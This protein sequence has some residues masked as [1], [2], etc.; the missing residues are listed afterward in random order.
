MLHCLSYQAALHRAN[1][2][3]IDAVTWNCTMQ[4]TTQELLATKRFRVVQHQWTSPTGEPLQ[5]E[6]IQHPG[7]VTI[8]PMLTSNSVCLI[9]NHRIAVDETLIELPAGTREPAEQP[10]ITAL[11]ELQEE[12]GYRAGSMEPLAD[13]YLSPGILNERMFVFVATDLSA[14]PTALEPEEEIQTLITDWEDAIAMT[15]DGRI[16]DAKT[17]AALHLYDHRRR[18]TTGAPS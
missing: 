13:F 8:I 10:Q 14:G 1:I 4:K 5:R 9:Q 17:I 16:R 3:A 15:I 7:A 12:T 18:D 11:R 2:D 6:S